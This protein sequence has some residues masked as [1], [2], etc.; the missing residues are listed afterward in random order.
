MFPFLLMG[1]NCSK[2][3]D[4]QPNVIKGRLMYGCATPAANIPLMLKAGSKFVETV[5]GI[6][7]VYTDEDGY[8]EFNFS[9]F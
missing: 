7:E 2:K 5:D 4:V 6:T 1:S 3:N 9:Q 8:F